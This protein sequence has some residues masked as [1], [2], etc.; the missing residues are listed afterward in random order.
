MENRSGGGA[1]VWGA[2]SGPDQWRA[3]EAAIRTRTAKS[4]YL[5][6]A[7][8]IIG[9]A[10]IWAE[11]HDDGAKAAALLA[12]RA[13][14]YAMRQ[15]ARSQEKGRRVSALPPSC[16]AS[17]AHSS[18]DMEERTAARDLITRAQHDAIDA[19][20]C[21]YIAAGES[22]RATARILGLSHTAVCKRLRAMRARIA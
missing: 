6:P 14:A 22:I 18:V 13:A 4:G 5:C 8:E 21:D 15:E 7:A 2:L 17:A 12:Y 3:L 9:A 1:P 20:I 10:W 19:A 11:E 16:A